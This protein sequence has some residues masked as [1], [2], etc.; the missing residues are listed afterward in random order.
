MN[1]IPIKETICVTGSKDRQREARREPETEGKKQKPKEET[2]ECNQQC[3]GG[4]CSEGDRQS[5]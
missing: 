4:G 5:R 3:E 2:Y 1:A